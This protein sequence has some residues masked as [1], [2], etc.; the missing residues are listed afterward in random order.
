M[1]THVRTYTRVVD[2]ISQEVQGHTRG[3]GSGY[4]H[5]HIDDA[6]KRTPEQREALRLK[7]APHRL[8]RK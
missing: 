3:V 4:H 5:T 7:F 8:P 6:P 2:G 1:N